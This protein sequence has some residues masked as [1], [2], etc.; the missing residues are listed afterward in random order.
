MTDE[1]APAQEPT[2]PRVTG[3][4]TGEDTGED[5]GAARSALPIEAA[6]DEGRP[7][8]IVRYGEISLKGGNRGEF[9]KLLRRAIWRAVREMGVRSVDRPRGRVM[10]RDPQ[11]P[12]RVAERAAMVFGVTSASPGWT[13]APKL[14]A[15]CAAARRATQAILSRRGS[16]DGSGLTFKVEVKRQDKGFPLTS[17]EAG[18]QIA[19]A[20]LADH[21]KLGVR[22]K[23]PDILLGVEIRQGEA[24]VFADRLRGPGGLPAG[25][26]GSAIALFSGGI[27]SPVAVWL[28]MKRGLRVTLLHFHSSPFVGDASRQKAIDLARVLSRWSGRIRLDIVQFANVQVAIKKSSPAPYRTILYRRAMNRIA[29]RVANQQEVTTFLTGESLGQ[30]ASQT[31]ENMTCIA[32]STDFLVLRPLVMFDKEETIA[33][34]KKIGTYEISVRPHPDCCTL[35]QPT[36]P[37]IRGEVAEVREIEAEIDLAPAIQEAVDTRETWRFE[38]GEPLIPRAQPEDEDEEHD[39]TRPS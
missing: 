12:H 32:E 39:A 4:A 22:M 26:M 9:E 27:D 21:P 18:R 8:V 16:R 6:P 25:S 31:L 2:Q 37:K 24:M 15:I 33:L 17:M 7:V 5:T 28:A 10:I 14:D 35:F 20:V 11:D 3:E 13:V 34:A 29:E 1:A 38:D 23:D 19:D 30:V 36:H